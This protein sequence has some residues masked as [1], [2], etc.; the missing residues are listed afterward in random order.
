VKKKKKKKSMVPPFATYTGI[1]GKKGG[2]LPYGATAYRYCAAIAA[3]EQ[4]IFPIE[5]PCQAPQKVVHLP[6]RI[7]ENGRQSRHKCAYV[8]HLWREERG[9]AQAP[10]RA[11]ARLHLRLSKRHLAH[12]RGPSHL[13]AARARRGRARLLGFPYTTPAPALLPRCSVKCRPPRLRGMKKLLTACP[14]YALIKLLA[15]AIPPRAL[16]KGLNHGT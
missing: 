13:P 11:Y 3:R 4:H 5:Q 1:L 15:K 16:L 6:W 12:S 9:A 2:R 7:A 8:K 14:A 10:R